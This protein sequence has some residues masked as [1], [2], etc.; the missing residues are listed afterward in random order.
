M[1]RAVAREAMW[2]RTRAKRMESA[3][4]WSGAN[5]PPHCQ[6]EQRHLSLPQSQLQ[7]QRP[8]LVRL[9]SAGSV[10]VMDV[11]DT[12]PLRERGKEARSVLAVLDYNAHTFFSPELASVLLFSSC[13]LRGRL[14][15]AV[16]SLFAKSRRSTSALPC[17]V[18]Q[19]AGGARL[20]RCRCRCRCRN[21]RAP[22]LHT[23]ALLS[24]FTPPSPSPI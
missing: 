9:A 17:R 15:A 6:S 7:L 1:L 14:S 4:R 20:F 22:T 8:V 10:G 2:A 18:C 5:L 11:W 12:R 21:S 19:R 23:R 24:P 16:S 13:P 3:V